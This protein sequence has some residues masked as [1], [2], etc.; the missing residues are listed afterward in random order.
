MNEKALF[1][2][3]SLGRASPLSQQ[4]K[5][6]KDGEKACQY[7][8]ISN[9]FLTPCSTRHSFKIPSETPTLNPPVKI[10]IIA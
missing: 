2:F 10:F 6:L 8:S 1:L 5:F 3:I 9:L 4:K 7:S